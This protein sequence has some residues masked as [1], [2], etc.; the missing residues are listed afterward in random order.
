MATLEVSFLHN[1]LEDR[2]RRLEAAIVSA[3]R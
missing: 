3:P 2:K 1:Q